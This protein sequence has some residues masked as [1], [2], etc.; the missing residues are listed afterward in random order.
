MFVPF[1]MY[2]PRHEV[3]NRSL[4]RGRAPLPTE[5]MDVCVQMSPNNSPLRNKI[6]EFALKGAVGSADGIFTGGTVERET[7]KLAVSRG[8]TRKDVYA[9]VI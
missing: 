2:S 7:R 3:I 4:S 8:I 9:R 6:V 1:K 5:I